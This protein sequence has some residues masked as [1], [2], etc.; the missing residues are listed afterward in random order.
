MSTEK[1]LATLL[2]VLQ[3]ASS[4]Q[5]ISSLLASATSLFTLLSNPCNVTLLTS[6][7]LSAPAIWG[8]STNLQTVVGVIDLFRSASYQLCQRHDNPPTANSNQAP[9]GLSLDTWTVAVLKGT[10]GAFPPSK[11]VLVLSGLLQGVHTRDPNRLSIT[12][13]DEL[14]KSVNVSLQN[15]PRTTAV[16]ERA[17]VVAI[18]QV[19]DILDIR[20]RRLLDHDMLLPILIHAM[21]SSEDGIHHGYFLGTLSAASVK[22]LR[23]IKKDDA[24]LSAIQI[25]KILRNLYFISSRLGIELLSQY[26]FVYLAAID[27]LSQYPTCAEGL[28]NEIQP[29]NAGTM[30]QHPLDRCQDVYYLNTA[31]HFAPIL[32]T[33]MACNL[34]ATAASPYLGTNGDQRSTEAFEAAHSVMLAIFAAADNIDVT[35]SLMEEYIKTVFEPLES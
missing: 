12:L 13:Q 33:R 11:R 32:D 17:V 10:G 19:F 15:D 8:A 4:E 25:L 6:Q 3:R 14:V 22:R 18:G 21:F 1:S 5:D 29:T 31:E 28:L 24:P 9:R 26:S 20:A 23:L 27:I 34:L 7:I 35:A 30:P 16:A 2:R